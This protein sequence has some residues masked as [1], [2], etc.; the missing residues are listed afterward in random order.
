MTD[1]IAPT[2]LTN[3]DQIMAMI[4][5][6]ESSLQQTL[7]S[8]ESLLHKIHVALHKDEECAILLSPEQLG[9][10][11]AGL[12][13][14]KGIVIALSGSTASKTKTGSGKSLKDVTLDDLGG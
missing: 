14:K 10:I 5:E 2:P 13:K 12:G 9:V 6:L 7:P 4:A 3:C 8:Y 1:Q 11:C